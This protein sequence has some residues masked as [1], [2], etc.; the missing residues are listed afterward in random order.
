MNARAP[1]SQVCGVKRGQWT[2][3][4]AGADVFWTS[5]G[6]HDV[7][8]AIAPGTNIPVKTGTFSP[9]KNAAYVFVFNGGAFEPIA[10]DDIDQYVQC[11]NV[12]LTGLALEIFVAP[13]G[14]KYDRGNG[15]LGT[16]NLPSAL[17]AETAD[18]QRVLIGWKERFATGSS[19][20]VPARVAITVPVSNRA[21]A[22]TDLRPSPVL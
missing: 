20:A 19:S 14:T 5:E 16:G 9:P 11:F 18:T 10:Y 1:Y 6:L 7:G 17:N 4:S 12:H 2:I 21:P 13:D 3:D 8:K 22:F 15:E